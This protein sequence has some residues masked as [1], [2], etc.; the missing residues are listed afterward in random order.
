MIIKMNRI[1]CSICSL[2]LRE[3]QQRMDGWIF[4]K[5]VASSRQP[6]LPGGNSSIK[7]IAQGATVMMWLAFTF[8]HPNLLG[9][10]WQ[11]NNSKT[12]A[13]VLI[14]WL[15]YWVCD[16]LP[17]LF[18]SSYLSFD[19]TLSVFVYFSPPSWCYFDYLH[20]FLVNLLC[21]LILLPIPFSGSF[22][23]PP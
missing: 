22:S 7:G 5:M 18:W 16:Y 13:A 1:L 6:Q 14:M 9:V 10:N 20:L 21:Q 4:N 8:P 15:K 11:Q 12:A 17:V 23:G 2:S 3:K 19:F